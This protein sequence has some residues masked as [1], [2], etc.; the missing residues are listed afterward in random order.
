M[1]SFKASRAFFSIK[2]SIFDGTVKPSAAMRIFDSHI[3]HIALYN[4]EIWAGYKICYQN[5]SLDE[6]LDMSFKCNNEFDNIFTRFS[7]YVSGVCSEATNFAVFSELGQFPMLISVIARCINF[8]IHTIQ[9][10]NESLLSEAYWE[11]CN[12]PVLKSSWLNFVKKNVLTGL[13]FSHQC[14]E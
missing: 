12:K 2:Q 13:G 11:Q 6:M 8:W 9:S 14:L 1:L 5:K 3:K 4:S 10:T 7:K